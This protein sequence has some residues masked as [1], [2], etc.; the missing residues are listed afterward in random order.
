MC[1]VFCPTVVL[2]M[3]CTKSTIQK[4][5][6]ESI[7]TQEKKQNYIVFKCNSQLHRQPSIA[8]LLLIKNMFQAC[9]RQKDTLFSI[10]CFNPNLI[11]R[12]MYKQ[13]KNN[14]SILSRV[15]FFCCCWRSSINNFHSKLCFLYSVQIVQ[16]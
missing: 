8:L 7:T 13:C 2:V 16:F 9:C 14:T 10:S 11:S 15:S 1:S 3:L 12:L 5:L 6:E 4:C